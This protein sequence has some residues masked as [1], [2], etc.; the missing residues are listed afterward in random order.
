MT[1]CI[2][3]APGRSSAGESAAADVRVRGGVVAF[4]SAAR[5]SER[6][7]ELHS[8]SLLC[9][10][11]TDVEGRARAVRPARDTPRARV[12]MTVRRGAGGGARRRPGRVRAIATLLVLVLLA[13]VVPAIGA[14]AESAREGATARRASRRMNDAD[15]RVDVG[16][17]APRSKAAT[18]A[19]VRVSR[20]RAPLE[21]PPRVFASD[22]A[23]DHR[24]SVARFP[25][26]S[27]L[28]NTPSFA[29][30]SSQGAS[31]KE[32]RASA[33]SFLRDGGHDTPLVIP[34]EV[35]V[36]LVGM[37]ADGGLAYA[38]DEAKLRSF[39]HASFASFRP[40]S[41]ATGKELE[42]EVEL[43]Y[44]VQHASASHVR[45]IEGA[46]RAGMR[47]VSDESPPREW[48]ERGGGGGA[49]GGAWRA[50]EVEA[51]GDV[52]DAI[53]RVYDDLFGD[54]KLSRRVEPV[55]LFVVSLDKPR[56]DPGG[57]AASASASRKPPESLTPDELR[58]SEGGYVYRYRYMGSEGATAAWLGRG[59]YAVLDLS[60]GPCSL[61]RIGGG[62]GERFDGDST[63][64]AEGVAVG[65]ALPRLA[66]T[67][68]PYARYAASTRGAHDVEDL[69]KRRDAAMFGR[70]SALVVSATRHL[71]A[72]DVKVETLDHAERVFVPVVALRDHA[73]FAPLHA[74]AG[75]RALDLE[76]LKAEASKLLQPRQSLSVV[77]GT[78]N[79]H[80]HEHLAAAV[81]RA[82]R[83]RS[84][85][86]RRNAGVGPGHGHTYHAS[87]RSRID[88]SALLREF[89]ASADLL[90]SGLIGAGTDP[91][92][93]ENDF[94]TE[95]ALATYAGTWNTTA[96]RGTRILPLYLLSLSGLPPGVLLDGESLVAADEDLVIVL[97]SVGESTSDASP[98]AD[99]KG[100]W[101]RDAD[102]ELEA[103]A[104]ELAA[105]AA[106]QADRLPRDDPRRASFAAAASAAAARVA[107]AG[108]GHREHVP[109]RF[110]SQGRPVLARPGEPTRHAVAGLAVA[111]SGL[112]SPSERFSRTRFARVENWLWAVGHHPF[113]PFTNCA[114]LSDALVDVARRNAI[115]SRLDASMRAVR[116]ALE[117][118]EAFAEEYLSEPFGDLGTAPAA[119]SA[120]SASSAASPPARREPRARA[121]TWLD[122]LYRDPDRANVPPLPQSVVAAVEARMETFEDDFA[123]VGATLYSLDLERA[124]EM[125]TSLLVD[126]RAFAAYVAEETS[127]AR[128]DLSCC[129]VEYAR[130]DAR[131]AAA[132]EGG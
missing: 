73:R 58:D 7:E 15:A 22:L 81:L 8:H 86:D 55:A 20:P 131:A 16:A 72:P 80:E 101:R 31:S 78:H 9:A 56:L 5:E 68:L 37:R 116:S 23:S 132:G 113:G 119:D 92:P 97:Q 64:D 36:V 104:A 100:A 122:A 111:L 57:G 107:E 21:P 69:K 2:A 67:F 128:D 47:R 103:A 85:A 48:T 98:G 74:S 125:S 76:T 52:E 53:A 89:R 126:A 1:T 44:N 66:P 79:L 129:G 114:T 17:A 40:S 30:P 94:L 25:S 59:R 82:R 3:L 4:E 34:M 71:L 14:E 45:A 65:W 27:P 124:H 12:R 26:L 83:T 84:V 88:A 13:R 130:T 29:I 75:A 90:T 62:D 99:A 120:A 19:K 11:K 91:S 93:D 61:A 106:D 118:V 38:L 63:E 41:M 18:R 127:K 6:E 110:T 109:L 95:A 77:T 115:I 33:R 43:K 35:N 50:Y 24:T 117:D 102:A 28:S 70:L 54:P 108:A 49:G 10:T 46:V 32:T 60:A 123:A 51:A 96:R 112:A 121:N 105:E 39:L 87:A 42:V